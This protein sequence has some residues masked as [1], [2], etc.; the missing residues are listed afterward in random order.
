M[1]VP[2]CLLACLRACACS[3]PPACV[4]CS[5]ITIIYPTRIFYKVVLVPTVTSVE[6]YAT[7]AP[8]RSFGRCVLVGSQLPEPTYK[9]LGKRRNGMPFI[10]ICGV[11]TGAIFGHRWNGCQHAETETDI[12]IL[13]HEARRSL[14][15]MFDDERV[16]DRRFE[17]CVSYPRR[18]SSGQYCTRAQT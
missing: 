2:F 9:L 10:D 14:R 16:A 8:Q 12:T 11:V 13:E 6:S 1:R 5:P 3:T 4:R 15:Y 18:K 7:T 17:T